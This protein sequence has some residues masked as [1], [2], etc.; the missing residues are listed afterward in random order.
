MTTI[1]AGQTAPSIRL[2]D[3]HEKPISLAES[4]KKGPV[5]VAFFKVSCPVCQYTFPF[6]ERL[7]K[8]YGNDRVSFL[9]I[10]Q[11]EAEDTLEFLS[12]Y[13]ITFPSLIDAPGYAV[14]NAYGLTNVPT[15][16]LIGMDGKVIVGGTGFDKA[17]LDKIAIA[18]G[19]HVGKPPAPVFRAGENVPDYKPG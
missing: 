18:L 2:N 12:E 1:L 3:A 4:L 10:S 11:D 8:A 7:H 17:N 13:G 5:V 9:A 19:K 16:F 14:S 15:V 6:L